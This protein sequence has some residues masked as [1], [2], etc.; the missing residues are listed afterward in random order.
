MPQHGSENALWLDEPGKT[1]GAR[2]VSEKAA[3]IVRSLFR[4]Q[5]VRHAIHTPVAG[6][7]RVAAGFAA[8]IAFGHGYRVVA[9][10]ERRL[11]EPGRRALIFKRLEI[12]IHL[13]VGRFL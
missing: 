12:G 4:A 13:A 2:Q 3:S 11:D 5:H 1:G 10:S 6:A 8:V 7:D 9:A